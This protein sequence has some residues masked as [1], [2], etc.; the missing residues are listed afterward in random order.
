M[1]R[2]IEH[3]SKDVKVKLLRFP[4]TWKTGSSL[5]PSSHMATHEPSRGRCGG[6]PAE[7]VDHIRM[8]C[9]SPKCA[10]CNRFHHES[11]ECIA[12]YIA[13]LRGTGDKA[14]ANHDLLVDVSQV[15]DVT[16]DLPATGHPDSAFLSQESSVATGMGAS[17]LGKTVVVK[18]LP[19]VWP[20]PADALESCLPQER[21]RQRGPHG[22]IAARDGFVEASPGVPA[23]RYYQCGIYECVDRP[24]PRA[25][26]PRERGRH[27]V[28]PD[29]VGSPAAAGRVT[30]ALET[31]SGDLHDRHTSG[32]LE[33]GKQNNAHTVD[34]AAAGNNRADQEKQAAIQT[35][36]S[37]LGFE[38]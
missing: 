27:A 35:R 20:T 24:P 29:R 19:S 17:P 2:Y 32:G 14:E 3:K 31:C 28:W 21:E 23:G 9:R 34:V 33:E 11:S 6:P 15:V 30:P 13:A 26:R 22:N 5:K 8:Q 25:G 12:T 1:H 4:R 18:T 7:K 16:G 37:F 36:A 10:K 38:R